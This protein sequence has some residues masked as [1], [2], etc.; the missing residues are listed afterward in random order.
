MDVMR[1]G[2]QGRNIVSNAMIAAS[3]QKTSSI[4]IYIPVMYFKTLLCPLVNLGMPK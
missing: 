1:G 3:T 4:I 2:L